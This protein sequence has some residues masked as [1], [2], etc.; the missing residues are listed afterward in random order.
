MIIHKKAVGG[1][2]LINSLIDNLKFEAHIPGYHFCG[3]GTNLKK[4]LAGGDSEI[5]K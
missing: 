3:P 1:R 4:R 5:N 2:G